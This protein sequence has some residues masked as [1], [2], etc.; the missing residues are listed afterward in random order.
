MSHDATRSETC[1]VW[2]NHADV[3]HALVEAFLEPPIIDLTP[4]SHAV[5]R[6]ES[7]L[8]SSTLGSD[9]GMAYD[10][11]PDRCASEAPSTKPG[12]PWIEGA[13]AAAA[14]SSE[15]WRDTPRATPSLYHHQPITSTVHLCASPYPRRRATLQ[16]QAYD[17]PWDGHAQ[18]GKAHVY[19]QLRALSPDMH[20][21][22][23][24]D[25]TEVHGGKRDGVYE[26]KEDACHE[27]A[28][29]M[30]VR[31]WSIVSE[32]RTFVHSV[33]RRRDGP[34]GDLCYR[35]ADDAVAFSAL[36]CTL[37][38]AGFRLCRTRHEETQRCSL[39]WVSRPVFN[40]F[41]DARPCRRQKLN[42]IPGAWRLG[43]KDALH[44]ALM[45]QAARVRDSKH[46][47]ACM[48]HTAE[49]HDVTHHSRAEGDM[50]RHTSGRTR[51]HGALL[52]SHEA[53]EE[54]E[55][56]EPGDVQPPSSHRW[57]PD[58]WVLPEEL[59]AAQAAVRAAP[60]HSRFIL[61]PTTS[62]C[63]RG[64]ALLR[65]GADATLVLSALTDTSSS[66]TMT[67]AQAAHSRGEGG[68]SGG[69]LRPGCARR[70]VLQR[71]EEDVCLIHGYKWDL[72]LYVVVTSYAPMRLYLYQ[73]GLVRFAT[74]LYPTK[75]AS[76]AAA[77]T[78]PSSWAEVTRS[79]M[80]Q[81]TNGACSG[82]DERKPCDMM[83]HEARSVRTHDQSTESAH[84]LGDAVTRQGCHTSHIE[85]EVGV[86]ETNVKPCNNDNDNDNDDDDDE[87]DDHSNDESC[88][89]AHLTNFAVSKAVVVEGAA[90]SA[91]PKW[92]LAALRAHLTREGWDWDASMT[93]IHDVLCRVFLSVLPDVRDELERVDGVQATHA[94]RSSESREHEK[95]SRR[96]PCTFRGVSSYFQLYGVDVLLRRP[97]GT[98][99]AS[100]SRVLEP[101]IMEV[102]IMPSLS[103]HYSL[104]DQHIK[105]NF[106]A[107]ALTLVGL[108]TPTLRPSM[109]TRRA[110][111]RSARN[112]RET[113][114]G[115][116]GGEDAVA[117]NTTTTALSYGDDFLDALGDDVDALEACLTAEEERCRAPRF[118]RL[119]PTATS[120]VQYASCLMPYA[121][122]R[123]SVTGQC[124][125]HELDAV[126]SAWERS[127]CAASSPPMETK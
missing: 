7:E 116:A 94:G 98:L 54:E 103:T 61:K 71:Y 93:R 8:P 37:A 35:L 16:L 2:T 46:V 74:A 39:S 105:G 3:K 122:G 114:E 117:T 30:H 100:M 110:T 102:N 115:K 53:E 9:G 65:G 56:R 113:R 45:A 82:F 72:R 76:S 124:S 77:A 90:Q 62:A 15:D 111:M 106:I 96:P 52:V 5:A 27:G 47:Y 101:V 120:D 20:T 85:E 25:T 4:P 49:R 79:N 17:R 112:V 97:T 34:Y 123:G 87:D 121:E 86:A 63:G 66:S 31:D 23:P 67:D 68:G 57:F 84:R 127:R 91:V 108:S 22:P 59:L 104:L 6:R 11:H 119:M 80:E 75:T 29:E 89:R 42:H 92:N 14:G 81:G 21:P 58:G 10:H 1:T 36:L 50:D 107:D 28:E 51:T 99:I 24:A 118:H 70:W 18:C 78:T 33:P 48:T 60:A 44:R 43:R 38:A 95:K 64:I 55:K 69:V 32:A 40:D 83:C 26:T 88:L 126:L 19:V 73:E 13:A 109:A 125:Y 12:E 41:C